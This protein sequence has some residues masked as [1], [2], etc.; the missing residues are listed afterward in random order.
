[1]KGTELVKEALPWTPAPWTRSLVA[2]ALALAGAL[3]TGERGQD[4]VLLAVA[5][6]GLAAVLHEG[7]TLVTMISDRLKVEVIQRTA[8]RR[9]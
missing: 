7:L 5:S 8:M 1:M 6:W 2:L 9:R 3:L 4:W